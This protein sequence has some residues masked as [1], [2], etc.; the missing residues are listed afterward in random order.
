MELKYKAIN[1][2]T[3]QVSEQVTILQDG[4]VEIEW[5]SGALTKYLPEQIDRDLTRYFSKQLTKEI[6][7][8]RWIGLTDKNG[9]RIF[10]DDIV[11]ITEDDGYKTQYL[12]CWDPQQNQFCLHWLAFVRGG[13]YVKQLSDVKLCESEITNTA[14]LL[15]DPS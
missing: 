9:R 5:T 1:I 2:R 6:N 7:L 12:V 13:Q 8:V 11:A 4:L 10:E 14:L 3:K 15:T